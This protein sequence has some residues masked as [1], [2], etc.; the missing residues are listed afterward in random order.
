MHKYGFAIFD[1]G[2]CLVHVFLIGGAVK[3]FGVLYVEF[4]QTF[5][6]SAQA[7]SW[8]NVFTQGLLLLLS[9]PVKLLLKT[10]LISKHFRKY[11]FEP[12]GS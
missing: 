9:K 8:I 5:S 2:C 3:S 7:A 10:R 4:I 6:T 11:S 12:D 1:T